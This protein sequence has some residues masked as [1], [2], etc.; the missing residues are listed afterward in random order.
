MPATNLNVAILPVDMTAGD[1][2]ANL[3][4]IEKRI[5]SLP[6]AIDLIVLPEMCNT[7]YTVDP[8]LATAY[9]ESVDGYSMT[10]L[11]AIAARRNAAIWGTMAMTDDNGALVNRG[12]M[13]DP[14][15]HTDYYDKHHLFTLGGENK[16]YT[17]GR[18]TP[19]V[20]EYKGWRLRMSICYDLRFPVWNRWNVRSSNYDVLIIPA[21]WPDARAI[22]WHTLLRAR[23][24]ENQAYVVGCNRLG[25]DPYGTYSIDISHVFNHW[26]DD[27]ADRTHD[28]VILATFDGA[29]LDRDRQRFP[30]LAGADDFDIITD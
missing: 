17:S 20:I 27:I 16:L 5:D 23:A 28:G 8:E 19:P 26:G 13:I 22:A 24:I 2:C 9:S 21:N 7:G 18:T 30:N 11:R 14:S 12:F 10:R 3:D 4:Y 25:S 1:A 6:A 29:A 15:G